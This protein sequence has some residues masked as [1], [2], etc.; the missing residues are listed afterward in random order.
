[1]K[2]V[3]LL[4]IFCFLFNNIFAQNNIKEYKKLEIY[5]FD[6]LRFAQETQTSF[7]FTK[8]K[9]IVSEANI[10]KDYKIRSKKQKQGYK[11]Y[12]FKDFNVQ[13]YK[14]SIHIISKHIEMVY[15]VF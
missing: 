9:M 13:R 4:V 14:D 3:I 1:M 15:R 5:K 6:S 2:E 12:E 10:D 7:R 11:L 8:D